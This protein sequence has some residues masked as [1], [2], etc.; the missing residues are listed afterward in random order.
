MPNVIGT[1][2]LVVTDVKCELYDSNETF[3][4]KKYTLGE[5]VEEFSKNFYIVKLCDTH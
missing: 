1:K 3:I 4:I 5:I 2:I